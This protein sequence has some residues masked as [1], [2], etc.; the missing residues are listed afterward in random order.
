[1]RVLLKRTWNQEK[2]VHKYCN[3]H[4]CWNPEQN[5]S[6]SRI[7][8]CF[9]VELNLNIWHWSDTTNFAFKSL[10][11]SVAERVRERDGSGTWSRGR[12]VA[13][14]VW[15]PWSRCTCRLNPGHQLHVICRQHLVVS[16][17]DVYSLSHLTIENLNWSCFT[18]THNAGVAKLMHLQ[19]LSRCKTS[20]IVRKIKD[21]RSTD[22]IRDIEQSSAFAFRWET[23]EKSGFRLGNDWIQRFG[24][25]MSLPWSTFAWMLP[26]SS[27]PLSASQATQQQEGQ[28]FILIMDLCAHI[29]WVLSLQMKNN[30]SAMHCLFHMN[31]SFPTHQFNRT[32]GLMDYRF[33]CLA[34]LGK[35]YFFSLVFAIFMLRSAQSELGTSSSQTLQCLLLIMETQDAS[36][37]FRGWE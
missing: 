8:C 16:R 5:S 15:E 14:S 30:D 4:V 10:W 18:V 27:S 34:T 22:Q 24:N 7:S 1:M 29:T 20:D 35:F 3:E 33:S 2:S 26:F 6:Q 13:Y 21:G 37:N 32:D 11:Y 28:Q 25:K 9:Q 36:D 12:N 17:F 31:S 23:W 19:S